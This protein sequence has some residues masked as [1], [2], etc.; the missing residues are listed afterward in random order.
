M[1]RELIERKSADLADPTQLGRQWN[2][3]QKLRS[4]L[5]KKV[6][7]KASKGRKIRYVVHSSLVNFMAP[8][9]L[10]WNDSA[11]DDLFRSLFVEAGEESIQGTSTFISVIEEQFHSPI[12]VF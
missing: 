3:L 10:S 5:K 8:V 2:E 1:L 11:M 12:E 6:D 9:P 4:K 7:T